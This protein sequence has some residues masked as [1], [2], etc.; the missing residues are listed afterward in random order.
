VRGVRLTCELPVSDLRALATAFPALLRW[1]RALEPGE[2]GRLLPE[3]DI[4]LVAG[5]DARRGGLRGPLPTG[6]AQVT[7]TE[8]TADLLEV[9]C[10]AP[11]VDAVVRAVD[12]ALPGALHLGV[13][14]EHRELAVLG[15]AYTATASLHTAAVDRDGELG[16]GEVRFRRL[17]VSARATTRR[18]GDRVR[19]RVR[20]RLRISPR[21]ALRP[22]ALALFFLR[23][24]WERDAQ[25]RLDDAVARLAAALAAGGLDRAVRELLLSGRESG[26]PEPRSR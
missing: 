18:R 14:G 16:V 23:R 3:D 8:D 7:V 25:S 26:P 20:V 4:R 10:T 2:D 15:R 17:L 21:G 22:A 24:K 6:T 13:R 11:G 19:V 12:P 9:C 5:A 1:W